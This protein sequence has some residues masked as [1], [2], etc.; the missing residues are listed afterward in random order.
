M[1]DDNDTPAP[2]DDEVAAIAGRGSSDLA[3]GN[4]GSWPHD[5]P[6]DTDKHASAERTAAAAGGSDDASD[7]SPGDAADVPVASENAAAGSGE[8]FPPVNS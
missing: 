6:D 5:D 1:A 8:A 4:L 7:A 2:S 3:S